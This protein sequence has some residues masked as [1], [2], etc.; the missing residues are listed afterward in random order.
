MASDSDLPGGWN[1]PD[2]EVLDQ[3][4]RWATFAAD[5]AVIDSFGQ[6][7]S[8]P[9]PDG[10]TQPLTDAEKSN[11]AVRAAIRALLANGLIQATIPEDG[12]VWF[13]P[14]PS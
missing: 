14:G 10:R 9:T 8:V 11:I 7:S 4:T 3:L 2:P 1:E 13:A 5:S 12:D 6:V